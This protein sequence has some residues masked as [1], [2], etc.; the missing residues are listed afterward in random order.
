MV[1]C[2]CRLFFSPYSHTGTAGWVC[3][4]G[5]SKIDMLFTRLP[6]HIPTIQTT[7]VSRFLERKLLW[8]LSLLLLIG[9]HWTFNVGHWPY[10]VRILFIVSS[11][12][13]QFW[14]N[15]RLIIIYNWLWNLWIIM[16]PYLNIAYEFAGKIA[17]TCALCTKR[18]HNS[19]TNDDNDDNN[20]DQPEHN[21]QVV[22]KDRA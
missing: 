8:L 14:E 10:G 1:C 3:E 18:F 19:Q 17:Y 2:T 12:I 6:I 5:I 4:M 11:Q 22:S 21:Y 7:N 9:W 15:W 20:N 13:F 16:K